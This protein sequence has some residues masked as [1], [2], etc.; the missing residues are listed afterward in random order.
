MTDNNK[1]IFKWTDKK[2][3][4]LIKLIKENEP[5]YNNKHKDHFKTKML[6]GIWSDIDSKLGKPRK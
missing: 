5:L 1:S 3:S 2:V 4:Q 6:D